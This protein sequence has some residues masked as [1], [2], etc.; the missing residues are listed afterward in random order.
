MSKNLV[1]VEAPN[2]CSAIK[3]YLGPDYNVI[4]SVG[5]VRS[6]P[7]KG[8]NID[9]KNG[10]EPTYEISPDKKDVV[11]KI[12]EAAKTAER[13]YLAADSDREG[14][15]IAWSIYDLLD[16]K[17]QKKC[18][19]IVYV[20]LTKKAIMAA[21]ENA[22]KIE[23]HMDKVYEQK[24]R[25]VLDRLIGYKIS[26]LLWTSVGNGTSAGRV[27]SIA[28]KYICSREKEIL[29]FK[30]QNFWYIEALLGC[31]NGDFRAK[32]VTKDKDNRYMDE[33]VAIEDFKKLETAKYKIESIEE[34]KRVV[35]PYPPFDTASLQTTCSSVFGWGA[36]KTA[37]IAQALYEKAFVSYIRTDSFNI[38]EDAINAAIKEIKSLYTSTYLA[39][40][41]QVYSKG[42]KE[43]KSGKE[44]KGNKDKGVKAQEAHECIRPT[45]VEDNGESL[46]D[47]DELKMYELIRSRFLA[48]QMKPMIAKTVTYNVKTS[49]GHTLIAKGQTIEFEGWMKAYKYSTAK[50]AILPLVEK[51]ELLTK[52]ELDKTEH[53]TQPPPRFNDGSIIK[54]ME[55]EGVGRPSTYATI[56][57]SIVKK[58]YAEKVK[59]GKGG[60]QATDLG[61]RIFDYLDPNFNK[62]FFM[63]VGYT[64][65][66][67]AELDEIGEGKK[68]FLDVVQKAY[69]S[70]Q[71]AIKT[72]QG[73][74][75]MSKGASTNEPCTVCK[76]G[77][78]IERNGK[79]G[80]FFACDQYPTCKTVYTKTEEGKFIIKE[81][82]GKA[83][84]E[85]G[86][87][88]SVCKK[89]EIVKKKGQ[90]GEFYCCNAY[91]KCKTIF[92]QD[93]DKFS[94]KPKGEYKD[95]K[96]DGKSK[97]S[98]KSNDS[99]DTPVKEDDDF[100]N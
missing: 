77:T 100:L 91:P 40:K 87:K 43:S 19:R 67:E 15:A 51:N 92:I 14:M 81:N 30:A 74:T 8:M 59:G 17:D 29:A 7:K 88:C 24:A 82:K 86:N 39:D 2:K 54:K 48:C 35:K 50:E 84:E 47:P 13:I 53:T 98:K 61:M 97:Y 90:Y 75:K 16:K 10:F 94:V 18:L 33:K 52:K 31:K 37:S 58:G 72:A 64:A 60:F 56:V 6:I 79:F 49:T 80:K 42:S 21:I 89:G 85:T 34:S 83:L 23:D 32:V 62:D 3:S 73:N 99:E 78:I 93:G 22:T 5:H 27:Q 1:I 95:Y 69:D 65:N 57:D 44:S 26:P 46:L 36:K 68:T 28:L 12:K 66:M 70:M 9:I 55:D 38:S 71:I 63:D 96:K 76:G 41:P 4:A 25:Q 45:H 20:E 11:K